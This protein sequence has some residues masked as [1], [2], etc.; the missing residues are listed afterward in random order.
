MQSRRRSQAPY[1][2]H[3]ESVLPA[4]LGQMDADPHSPTYGVG[5]R[6]FWGWKLIDFPNATFQGAANGL[7][8]L[9][10]VGALDGDIAAAISPR[11]AALAAGTASIIRPDGSLEEAFPFEGSFCVSALV[12]YD[13]LSALE[14]LGD[15]LDGE[16]RALVLRT[17]SRIALFLRR[18]DE[19]HGFISNHLATA[20]AFFYKYSALGGGDEWARGEA[21]IG[22]IL[23]AQSGEGWYREYEGADPGYQTLALNYLADAHRLRPDEA[24]WGSMERA[25]RFVWHFAHPDGSFG[26]WYG[27][28]N[29]RFYYPGGIR[30]LARGMPEAAALDA[31][32]AR[33]VGAMACVGLSAMDAPN[34]I[35]MFNSY[36][37]AV[38]QEADQAGAPER[39]VPL[40]PCEERGRWL[41]QFPQAGLVVRSAP[42]SYSVV[43][44]SK[45]GVVA[46]YDRDSGAMRWDC[47]VVV[48]D[49][50]GA[51]YSSQ[52]FQAPQALLV[53]DDAIRLEAALT[54]MKH[55]RPGPWK[56]VALRLAAL[57]VMR[58]PWLRDLVKRCLVWL[59]ITGKT[60]SK[61]RLVRTLRWDEHDA[62]SIEDTVT[63][64]DG[65]RLE[66]LPGAVFGH[67]HMASC[68]Y[69]QRGDS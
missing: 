16:T 8:R 54:P 63:A 1:M 6:L 50:S 9:V 69:W 11:I 66:P 35:P 19:R 4:V 20:A 5:D 52:A 32:M 34:M 58:L 24:L 59:L 56:F 36:C 48:R 40:L 67:I 23:D 18:S 30:L 29:T 14:A 61:G 41:R 39:D 45:G 10:A 62:L 31:F 2:A 64:R 44:T 7:A 60:G 26:G 27:S 13:L 68:G 15:G 28:R 3:I 42:Q 22:R 55:M 17:A 38:Q 33:A 49:D 57:S 37:W 47:G 43:S 12:G 51:R 65:S 25:V 21:L 46:H 53:A